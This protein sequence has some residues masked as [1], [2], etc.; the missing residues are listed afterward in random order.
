MCM[1]VLLGGYLQVKVVVIFICV[2]TIDPHHMTFPLDHCVLILLLK[3]L[4]D[5]VSAFLLPA[6][7]H[8]V[9]PGDTQVSFSTF[10]VPSWSLH[11]IFV[12][13]GG[14]SDADDCTQDL[15]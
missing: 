11:H 4:N 2:V 14:H 3:H 9:I 7:F 5:G 15:E 12:D 8:E 6:V 1:I 13:Q 10:K